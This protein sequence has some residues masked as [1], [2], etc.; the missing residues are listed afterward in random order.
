[1]A[2]FH[3]GLSITTSYPM[4]KKVMYFKVFAWAMLGVSIILALWLTPII[5]EWWSLL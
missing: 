2:L 1:M 4:T 5:L 3:G